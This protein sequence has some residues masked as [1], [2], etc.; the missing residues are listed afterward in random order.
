MWALN[1]SR[2]ANVNATR[3]AEE[4]ERANEAA[5]LAT[6]QAKQ[7]KDE[8]DEKSRILEI[9]RQKTAKTKIM[10]T[11]VAL[12]NNEHRFAEDTL[13]SISSERR[14][15]E[16]QLLNR[17]LN[18]NSIHCFG[19][20]NIERV[21]WAPDG[22]YL[23]GIDFDGRF[24]CWKAENGIAVF[25]ESTEKV[26]A[27]NSCTFEMAQ[28]TFGVWVADQ[29]RLWTSQLPRFNNEKTV[30]KAEGTIL[31]L[32]VNEAADQI[33]VLEEDDQAQVEAKLVQLETGRE[34][35]SEPVS[36]DSIHV[37]IEHTISFSNSGHHFALGYK[38][39]PVRILDAKDGRLLKTVGFE[40]EY[41]AKK[42]DFS[43]DGRY[44]ASCHQNNI[45]V[46][47]LD[48]DKRTEW[49]AQHE[50]DINRLVYMPDNG[51]LVTIG[52]DGVLKLWD[53]YSGRLILTRS[54][55]RGSI[56]SCLPSPDGRRIAT[57]AD[58]G[59]RIWNLNESP[60]GLR[61][62]H[63]DDEVQS[64]ALSS[65]GQKLASYGRDKKLVIWDTQQATIDHVIDTK[66]CV[67]INLVFS[68]DGTE[69]AGIGSK[70]V[71]SVWSIS[72][73]ELLRSVKAHSGFGTSLTYFENGKR[74]ISTG[75]DPVAKIWD[76]QD[77][78]KPIKIIELPRVEDGVFTGS[79]AV[80]K[81]YVAVAWTNGKILLL[82]R[83]DLEPICEFEYSDTA[84][85][86]VFSLD[87]Q[88]LIV[89]MGGRG[90]NSAKIVVWDIPNQ[91]RALNIDAHTRWIT[92]VRYLYPDRVVSSSKDG[93][94]KVWDIQNGELLFEF[95]DH[96]GAVQG[97]DLDAKSHILATCSSDHSIQLYDFQTKPIRSIIKNPDQ[98]VEA[99]TLDDVGD[100]IVYGTG[101]TNQLINDYGRIVVW[102]RKN[103]K[104]RFE[105]ETDARPIF[106]AFDQELKNLQVALLGNEG[107]YYQ[108]INGNTGELIET[109]DTQRE[110]VYTHLSVN[111]RWFIYA[112][113]VASDVYL[114]NRSQQG[115][116]RYLAERSLVS[117]KSLAWHT[118]QAK[119]FRSANQKF[120]ET[121][122]LSQCVMLSD[123]R[124]EYVEQFVEVAQKLKASSEA[125][126]TMFIPDFIHELMAELEERERDDE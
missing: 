124:P 104:K 34:I 4:T 49:S 40:V 120:P 10:L 59:L 122:H 93:T 20:P 87:S 73:G 106:I 48:S 70:G 61:L 125:S 81:N 57:I 83:T 67:P 90:T 126:E 97:M 15:I 7:L 96:S 116:E 103:W 95:A 43:P 101:N 115:D 80:D 53:T 37:G 78:A 76:A 75:E 21:A 113:S 27:G 31:A 68:P 107:V 26:L 38:H 66:D 72:S 63:H 102:D 123:F 8:R 109:S 98:R 119:L 45:V 16:W 77:L 35:W 13:D 2:R 121:F 85:D 69:L 111:G 5:N 55:H 50:G 71:L 94:C 58:D 62:D 64:V 33:L 91:K 112:N 82:N 60:A 46:A 56:K 9:S 88:F 74:L 22:R 3:K 105:L 32:K 51:R 18:G 108:V 47:S 52:D 99:I 29:A 44:I 117:Q 6:A 12:K 79:C 23:Y 86:M 100:R 11:Q 14:H 84:V 54:G 89:G 25:E 28:G 42:I 118:Q 30:W 110:G 65:N 1:E 39:G 114:V 24:L 19:L 41:A 92:S 17:I 36:T